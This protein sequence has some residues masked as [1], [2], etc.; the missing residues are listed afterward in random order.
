MSTETIFQIHL[1]LGYVAWLL[2]SGAYVMPWLKSMDGFKAHR[3]IATLHS[4]RFFG[5]VF[6]IPG[7]VG[8]NLPASFASFAAYGDFATGV[9]AIL[10]L[11]TVR[12]RALFLVLRRR[13]QS[14]GRGRSH[15]R[16][17][18]RCPGR[19]SCAGGTVG[20][21]LRNPDHLCAGPD[22]Y[23]LRRFLFAD[24]FS[25]EEDQL[26][27]CRT[28]DYELRAESVTPFGA[29]P[30]RFYGGKATAVW[31]VLGSGQTGLNPDRSL[32]HQE[33]TG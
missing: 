14:R 23:A 5:L 2:C 10:A 17:L 6:L 16:L 11:L 19:S 25:T 31:R 24:A 20:R 9:L 1:V 21:H 15:R 30:N 13:L 18:P 32:P 26:D 33:P 28:D 3:A 29:R 27:T 12:V 7:V 8:P 22:D 4:F